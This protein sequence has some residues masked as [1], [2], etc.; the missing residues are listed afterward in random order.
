MFFV[1]HM[2]AR[3]DMSSD[4]NRHLNIRNTKPI[5]L[6]PLTP[7]QALRHA[8]Q[9]PAPEHDAKQPKKK[10]KTRAASAAPKKG[11]ARGSK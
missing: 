3:S 1:M 2:G 10:A 11:N 6:A 9:V 8:M 7:E 5:S 4:Q